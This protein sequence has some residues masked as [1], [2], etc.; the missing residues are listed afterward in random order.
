MGWQDKPLAN[1]TKFCASY[2][3]SIDAKYHNDF[4]EIAIAEE[5]ERRRE[6]RKGLSILSK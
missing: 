3:A 1:L 6:Q 2:Q 5:I 4:K